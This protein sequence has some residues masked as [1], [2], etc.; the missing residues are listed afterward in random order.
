[1]AFVNVWIHA[2]WGTK[3]HASILVPEVKNL[4]CTHIRENATAKGFYVNEVNG[5]LNHLHCLMALKSDWSVAKQMQ[6][7]KGEAANWFN[8]NGILSHRLEWA[9][10]YFAASVSESKLNIVRNYI[11]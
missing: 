4:V 3:Q 7:I 2:V 10:E 6:M 9:D 8:K 11:R 5:Y 1:M